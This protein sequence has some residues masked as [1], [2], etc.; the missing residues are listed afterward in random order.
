MVVSGAFHVVDFF[1]PFLFP[2]LINLQL[3]GEGIHSRK[4]GGGLYDDVKKVVS[5][6]GRNN[7]NHTLVEQETTVQ[8]NPTN[9]LYTKEKLTVS[10]LRLWC[11]GLK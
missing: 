2:I 1:L 4:L 8:K 9:M 3:K 5:N 7:L 10:S 11:S 6:Q